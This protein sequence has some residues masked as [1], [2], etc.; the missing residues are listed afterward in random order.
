MLFP[1]HW[2]LKKK[3]AQGTARARPRRLRPTVGVRE[4]DEGVSDREVILI[5]NK[6]EKQMKMRRGKPEERSRHTANVIE[7]VFSTR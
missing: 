7:S 6:H 5:A 1:A 4:Y 2:I 3:T